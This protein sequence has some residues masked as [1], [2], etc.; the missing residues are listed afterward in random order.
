VAIPAAVLAHYF[1]GKIQELF[2]EIDELLMGFLP[3]LERYE[4]KL[5]LT[6]QTTAASEPAPEPA[7]P[8]PVTAAS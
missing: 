2:R 8:P 4:G 7:P 6:R 1:E 5:R 3:Q